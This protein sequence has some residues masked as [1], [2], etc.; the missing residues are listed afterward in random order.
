MTI[1]RTSRSVNQGVRR[2]QFWPLGRENAAFDLP[3]AQGVD[4]F[5]G[6]SIDLPRSISESR[7][8]VF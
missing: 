4:R 1:A 8:A 6:S 5:D 2:R 3:I 7:L